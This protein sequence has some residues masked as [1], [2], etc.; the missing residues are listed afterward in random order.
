MIFLIRIYNLQAFF[1]KVF[2]FYLNL[3]RKRTKFGVPNH[4]RGFIWQCFAEVSEYMNDPQKQNI[5]SN[6]VNQAFSEDE[7]Q[8]K[9]ILHDIDRTCP[10]HVFFKEKSGIG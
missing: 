10:K 4:L 8:Y 1:Q 7:S 5:Y 2:D 6:I 3:V 9:V